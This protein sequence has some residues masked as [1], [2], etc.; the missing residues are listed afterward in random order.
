MP[1][2]S[3]QDIATLSLSARERIRPHIYETPLLPSRI[4]GSSLLYKTENFQITGSFKLRGAI[5]KLSSPT[6]SSA[7]TKLITASSGNHG[8]GAA[9][10]AQK[11]NSQL[12]VVLPETVVPSKLSKIKNY[13]V[14]VLLHGSETGQAEQEAQR[15][16]RE[17][18]Y[19]YISP[20]ND[21]NIISGQATIGLEILSQSTT[22]IDSI[23]ISLGGGGLVSGIGSVFK[24]QSPETKIYGI[25]ASNSKALAES[26]QA[27]KVVET[28]HKETIADA[29][30][31]G[32]DED[33]I[34][35]PL[36]SA[37]IDELIECSE[38]EIE[39]AMR[40]L[41][42]EENM[43]V[44]GSAALALAGFLKVQRERSEK[45]R[46]GTSV[47]VLCGANYDK[48]R[49]LKILNG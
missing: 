19:T 21:I 11:L 40:V 39:E 23:F 10:A 15:L 43:I 36:A 41:A 26:I 33:T 20:Y 47:V 46:E 37:V 25:S 29:V 28:K 13:R 49:I 48:E 44:E 22:P 30:A 38:S 14:N 4:H 32:I 27:G 45:E 2:P 24:T 31:G 17:E 12:T 1:P 18:N 35:L 16:A 34:T 3:I 7:A 42:W 8:I 6:S 9:C 5:A